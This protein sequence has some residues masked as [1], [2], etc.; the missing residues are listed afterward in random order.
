MWIHK[1]RNPNQNFKRGGCMFSIFL[2]EEKD[3]QRGLFKMT[4]FSA[5]EPKQLGVILK[6]MQRIKDGYAW[7]LDGCVFCIQPFQNQSRYSL[8]GYRIF[9]NTSIETGMYLYDI[10]L[11]RLGGQILGIEC[12]IK[13]PSKKSSDWI[14][15]LRSDTSFQM[16][17]PRGLF[18]KNGCGIIVVNDTVILQMR[19]RNKLKVYEALKKI[20]SIRE[21][22]LSSVEYDLFSCSKEA[23]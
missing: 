22:L 13:C 1:S 23:G 8:K 9:F 20:D 2:W 15:G 14:S 18:N 16:T 12:V 5:V 21:E 17:D 3:V 6:D 7:F 4:C 19:N 10:T 11:G